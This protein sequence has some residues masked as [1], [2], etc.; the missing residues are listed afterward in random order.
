[1][2]KLQFDYIRQWFDGYVQTYSDIEP[3]GL[4]NITLKID[5]T[6][7]VCDIMELLADGEGLT[8]DQTLIARTIALLH[9]VGRFPQYR[10]WQTFRD[11]DSDNHARLSIEVIREHTVLEGVPDDERILIEEAVRFHNLLKVPSRL[12]SPTSLFLRMIRDADKLDI[13]RVFMEYFSK[14]P[15]ERPSAVLLG[16]PELPG[17]SPECLEALS[18]GRI[19]TLESVTRLNDFRLLLVSWAYDLSFSSSFALLHRFN[20]LQALADSLPGQQDI[21]AAIDAAIGH[22]AHKASG[23]H[24]DMPTD[25]TRHTSQLMHNKGAFD[26][27]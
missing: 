12:K 2:N 16:F 19:V 3:A 5:H 18:A 17:V 14:E 11:S 13:W 10:R 23:I 27:V 4:R 9:D 8:P 21:K 20:Y 15:D 1:M 7:K 26:G 24:L 22:V 25:D 6:H